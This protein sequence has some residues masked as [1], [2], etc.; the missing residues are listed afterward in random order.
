MTVALIVISL[1]LVLTWFLAR[2]GAR[3]NGAD[4][5]RPTLNILDGINRLYCRRVHRLVSEPLQLAPSE[6][7]IVVCNHVSGL[8]P[9]LLL[10]IS[11]RPLRFLIAQSEYERWWLNWLFK[12]IK[13]IP[14]RRSGRVDR[15][16]SAAQ[17]ALQDGEVMALFPQGKLVPEGAPPVRL[18]RGAVYLADLAQV[19]IIPVRIDGVAAQG[20]T[21]LAVFVPGRV[22]IRVADK[23]PSNMSAEARMSAIEEFITATPEPGL[24]G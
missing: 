15:S 12:R 23:L 2:A 5:N 16:L 4:W 9:M 13:C 8:D 7:A 18:K 6:G 22:R 1:A 3:A 17:Q 10:A 24:T 14:V 21:I 11:S 20:W 19:P